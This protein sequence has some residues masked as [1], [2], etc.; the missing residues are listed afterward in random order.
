MPAPADDCAKDDATAAHM[1]DGHGIHPHRATVWS[2][3]SLLLAAGAA[4]AAAQIGCGRQ[5]QVRTLPGGDMLTAADVTRAEPSEAA[6]IG[7]VVAGMT[8]AAYRLLR[9]DATAANWIASPLS[10]ACAFAM[11]RVGARGST[12]EQ[13]DEFFGFPTRG[14]DDAFNAI[15]ARLV[16]GHVPSRPIDSATVS[17]RKPGDPP[18][19]P[20]VS[21]GNAL[22]LQNGF[23]VGAAFLDA[24]AAD[25]GSGVHLVDFTKPDATDALDAWVSAQTADRITKLFDSLDPATKLVLANAVFFQGDW[26]AAFDPTMTQP[27]MFTRSDRTSTS[28]PMMHK[29]GTFRYGTVRGAQVLELP[30][31]KGPYAMWVMLPAP[32]TSPDDMLTPAAMAASAA[33]LDTTRVDVYL[34]RFD[35]ATNIDLAGTLKSLAVTAPFS[36]AAADFSGIAR[37]LYIG[38]AIHQAN[39]TVGE[40]G[41]VAA[42]VTA[43][44]MMPTSARAPGAMPVFRA[45]RPFAFAIVGDDHHVPLF[46]GRVTEPSVTS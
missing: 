28:V 26:V 46:V 21:L 40:Y 39:V 41:T 18:A 6:P 27:T 34:P 45:D 36:R 3:R 9:A 20:T 37:D 35:Y 8:D 10:L 30:Y 4:L 24:L 25:Y 31:A 15:T 42:A 12:A 14:R 17:S 43:I 44:S 11:A 13:L 32:G 2:R 23:R 38:Q 5:Q 22:F 16:T 33:S 7:P 19:P 29:A 1:I